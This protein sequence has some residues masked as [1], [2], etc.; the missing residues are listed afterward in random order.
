MQHVPFEAAL[1]YPGV[2][3][4]LDTYIQQMEKYQ[5]KYTYDEVALDGWIAADQF[6]TGL[7]AVGKNLTQKKLVA[8]INNETAYN[9]GGLTTPGQLETSALRVPAAVLPGRRRGAERRL[10]AGL[11]PGTNGQ[12]FTCFGPEQHHAGARARA[13]RAP[14]G[15]DP[16]LGLP[17]R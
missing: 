2:Y 1:A 5:P 16:R 8:A 6:V 11:R 12:V 7:K 17:I 13:P 15:P 3:P 9:G 4:G 10:R 14:R